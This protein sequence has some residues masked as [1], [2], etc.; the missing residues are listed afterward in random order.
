MIIIIFIIFII[1]IFF[2]TL[3]IFIFF[4][5]FIMFIINFICFIMLI[6][7]IIIYIIFCII[8]IKI[9]IMDGNITAGIEFGIVL[10]NIFWRVWLLCLLGKNLSNWKMII[11]II[12][13]FYWVLLKISGYFVRFFV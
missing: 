5:C 1:F 2:I 4:I 10:P 3:I 6:I 8:N 11:F 12:F 9:D 7:N 13:Y